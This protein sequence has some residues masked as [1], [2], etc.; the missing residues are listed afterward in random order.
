MRRGRLSGYK[1]VNEKFKSEKGQ[2]EVYASMSLYWQSFQDGL[3]QARPSASMSNVLV[4]LAVKC[5]IDVDIR[6]VQCFEGEMD[7]RMDGGKMEE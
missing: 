5:G 3:Y 2:G 6:A 7:G 4:A 1:V